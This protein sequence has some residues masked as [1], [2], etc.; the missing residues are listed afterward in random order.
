MMPRGSMPRIEPDTVEQLQRGR[1][2]GAGARHLIEEIVV[3]KRLDD[4]D[5]HAFLRQCEREAQSDRPG[6]D[7]DDRDPT[8]RSTVI[9]QRVTSAPPRPSPR[10]PSRCG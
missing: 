2:V 3:P 7:N 6:A 1:M 4:A 10:R 5:C 8:M 9:R